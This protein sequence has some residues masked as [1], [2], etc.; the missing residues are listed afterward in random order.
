MLSLLASILVTVPAVQTATSTEPALDLLWS[1]ALEAEKTGDLQEKERALWGWMTLKQEVRSI[2]EPFQ[3]WTDRLQKRLETSGAVRVFAA[4][5]QDRVRLTV[6]DPAQIL[7]RVQVYIAT[8]Q[9]YRLLTRLDS[10]A[11]NRN[12]YGGIGPLDSDAKVMVQAY[13]RWPHDHLLAKAVYLE[14]QGTLPGPKFEP[15]V[16]AACLRCDEPKRYV[17]YNG[18]V[19]WLV[20]LA[21]F[22]TGLAAGAAWQ[23][24]TWR[25]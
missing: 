24:Y 2:P 18:S 16:A 10:H 17:P 14:Q 11:V 12:E 23:E 3:A 5:L 22:S 20:G 4:R 7:G 6:N 15:A 13:L 9:G 19:W 1:V 8:P 25:K 21:V